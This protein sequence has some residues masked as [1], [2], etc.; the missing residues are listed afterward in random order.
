MTRE[1]LIPKN[2]ATDKQSVLDSYD[3]WGQYVYGFLLR[4]LSSPT[5]AAELTVS[6]FS[7]FRGK[8]VQPA[9]L[10][11]KARQL[12]IEVLQQTNELRQREAVNFDFKQAQRQSSSDGLH[13]REKLD[14]VQSALEPKCKTILEMA[15]FNGLSQKDIEAALNLPDGSTGTRLRRAVNDLR[16][17]FSLN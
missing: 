9:E 14:N 17:V 6:V 16:R 2:D 12:A 3:L 7:A 8:A 5:L 10:L 4:A 15:L 1:H 13:L 11:N